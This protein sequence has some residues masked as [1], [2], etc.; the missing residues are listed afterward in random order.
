MTRYIKISEIPTI[1]KNLSNHRKIAII[2][3]DNIISKRET[4][5]LEDMGL[6]NNPN[7]LIIKVPCGDKCKS[8][9]LVETI[10]E[11]LDEQK[12]NRD[13]YIIN[14]GGGAICDLGGFTA[15]TYMRG[16]RFVNIPTTLTAM[17][18]AAWGGKTAINFKNKKNLIGT[19]YH[20]EQH[21]ICTA[22]LK[23][24][25]YSE[26][27]SGWGEVVKYGLLKGKA[28]Y[29]EIT[30]I[31]D[32]TQTEVITPRLIDECIQYKRDLVEK[33]FKDQGLRRTLNLGH[34]SGHAFESL[35]FLRKDQKIVPHGVAV[36]AGIVI[37]L[38]ISYRKLNLDEYVLTKTARYI[39][40]TFP[41]TLFS[42]NN[43]SQLWQLAMQDKKNRHD[44]GVTMVL[45]KD[46]GKPVVTHDIDKKLWLEALDFYQDFM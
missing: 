35:Y 18:D 9:R 2:T 46:I 32:I 25:P 1:L 15:S 36:A 33:D 3:D 22:F 14:L 8:L 24:L 42:C 17:I 43:Y 20:A 7:Q 21:Y 26:L 6:K 39:K 4:R 37:A 12:F 41:K 16:M 34:T 44:K 10:W 11:K 28:L 5:F 40:S 19:F 29:D 38:Y 45:M 23:S 27:L 31:E 13:D 30:H